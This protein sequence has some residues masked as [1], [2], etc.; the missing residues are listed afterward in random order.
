MKS[1]CGRQPASPL[2]QGHRKTIPL[3]G[4]GLNRTT[5]EIDQK[6][7]PPSARVWFL[8]CLGNACRPD[9]PF[10]QAIA[11]FESNS[12]YPARVTWVPN[13]F[14]TL[15][16][17]HPDGDTVLVTRPMIGVTWGEDLRFMCDHRRPVNRWCTEGC[18]DA[19]S[20]SSMFGGRSGLFPPETHRKWWGA[21]P[22]DFSGWLPG[23]KRPSRPSK[24][25]ISCVS[26]A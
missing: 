20:K 9:S 14:W 24:S 5:F 26:V 22:P 21:K 2:R 13:V 19:S 16:V 23:G 7:A 6:S 18:Q 4:F 1:T 15:V 17:A 10:L 11:S 12:P 25:T 8:I 3:V